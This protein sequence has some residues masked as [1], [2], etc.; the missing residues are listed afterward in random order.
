MTTDSMQA[1]KAAAEVFEGGV[2][3]PTNQTLR[4]VYDEI[5]KARGDKEFMAAFNQTL[6]DGKADIPE[7][8]GFELYSV[9]NEG[10]AHFRNANGARVEYD[11]DGVRKEQWGEEK[12]DREFVVQD[13]GSAKHSVKKHETVWGVAK[14]VLREKLGREP[15]NKEVAE[16]VKKLADASDIKNPDIVHPG[17]E[18]VVPTDDV[19]AI[20]ERHGE[21]HIGRDQN[22]RVTDVV[23]PDGTNV[24]IERDEEGGAKAVTVKTKDGEPRRYE[25]DG[26]QWFVVDEKSGE[27]KPINGAV[28]ERQNGDIVIDDNDAQPHRIKVKKDGTLVEVAP[29]AEGK[30]KKTITT[31]DGEVTVKDAPKAQAKR[32]AE[33]AGGADEADGAEG[34]AADPSKASGA[35]DAADNE[36][37]QSGQAQVEGNYRTPKDGDYTVCHL[38]PDGNPDEFS[39][40]D[41]NGNDVRYRKGPNGWESDESG[42]WAKIDADMDVVRRADGTVTIS[43]ARSTG[44]GRV[45]KTVTLKPDH[46]GDS[47]EEIKQP[48]Q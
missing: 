7:L 14:D 4:G 13:D 15:N 38:G 12:N 31:P 3:S 44:V 28:E 36:A 40:R 21:H 11:A 9:D 17:Q 23:S 25:K 35:D 1:G 2:K 24:R 19:A 47:T 37:T 8:K 32:D 18:I 6:S 22:G 16:E 26:D 45:V 46:T 48:V 27:K 42:E 10:D 29:D 34:G 43:I 5:G 20:K 39:H 30:E 41:A 33:D